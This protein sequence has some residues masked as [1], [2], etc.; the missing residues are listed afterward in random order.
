MVENLEISSQDLENA[1]KNK[2]F[3]LYYQPEFNISTSTFE[4]VEALIRWNHPNYGLLLPGQ[5]IYRAEECSLIEEL[6]EWVLYTA[7]KQNKE[8][9]NKGL[10]AV[11]IA[12]NVSGMQFDSPDFARLVLDILQKHN[13]EPHYLELEL[14]ENMIIDCNDQQTIET[15][16][17]L[18][19]QGVQ[20]ALDDFGTG[21][22]TI[23]YLNLIP[24]NRIK[25]DKSYIENINSDPKDAAI[26]KAIID[27]AADSNL[28][29]LAEGIESLKQLQ[30]VAEIKGVETQ[31]FYFSHP[32]PATE[33]EKF[34]RENFKQGK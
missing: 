12:V 1:L 21:H 33:V 30:A 25:I 22:S 9:Q 34:L 11:R 17:Y 28:Q 5:F 6:G 16:K 18:S 27:L 4:A 13:L 2:E 19:D 7:I 10:P 15:I 20:I 23:S 3:I 32:L 8:W 29:V 26:V 24:V 14:N 31:G